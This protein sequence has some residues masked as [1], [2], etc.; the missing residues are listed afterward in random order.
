LWGKFGQR[1][2]LPKTEYITELH[3]FLN[4]LT[5]PKTLVD[6]LHLI[7]EDLAMISYTTNDDFLKPSGKTSVVI[8]AFTTACARMRLYKLLDTLQESVL[9]MDTDSVIF[10]SK[11]DSHPLESYVGDSLGF[12]TD[13]IVSEYGHGT[14]ITEF[15]SG[16]PK[17]YG[18]LMS[19]GKDCWKVK[20]ISQNYETCQTMSYETI[21][22]IVTNGLRETVKLTSH[23]ITRDK[24]T[25]K[26]T[27]KDAPKTYRVVFD[28]AFVDEEL[29]AWPYGYTQV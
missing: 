27:N 23:L 28:K 25:C 8:A 17:N 29:V 9:Y 10:V 26:L 5:S 11:K 6:D 3:Q 21:L 18:Y 12:V 13:E 19:N 16:G 24:K 4:H 7:N 2:N 15:V 14:Y 20:G 22:N 1:E